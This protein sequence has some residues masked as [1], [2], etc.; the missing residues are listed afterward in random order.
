MC[1][2]RSI[3]C[4]YDRLDIHISIWCTPRKERKRQN[5]IVNDDCFGGI[6]NCRRVNWCSAANCMLI[7]LIGAWFWFCSIAMKSKIRCLRARIYCIR[8]LAVWNRIL[9]VVHLAD[10][11][12][13]WARL[14]WCR[15]ESHLRQFNR[16]VRVCMSV[17][18]PVIETVSLSIQHD[19]T[20]N[21]VALFHFH[22]SLEHRH[23]TIIAATA[24]AAAYFWMF[25]THMTHARS[26]QSI[27]KKAY[28]MKRHDWP[29]IICCACVRA[30]VRECVCV[31]AHL[32]SD[33]TVRHTHTYIHACLLIRMSIYHAN[34][35][36]ACSTI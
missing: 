19:L 21:P 20:R 34:L 25:N 28:E 16:N 7:F 23:F 32:F 9:T 13:R 27:N 10:T 1:D 29:Y 4:L 17:C 5:S 2:V 14:W 6:S 3:V 22:H 33:G 12:L 11:S 8:V 15:I 24:G 35:M 26:F 30:C 36:H 18:L 31:N